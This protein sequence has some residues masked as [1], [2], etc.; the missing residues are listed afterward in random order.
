MKNSPVNLIPVLALLLLVAGCAGVQQTPVALAP[1]QTLVIKVDSYKF[2]PNY[3]QARQ[4]DL[5]IDLE[6]ISGS[7]HNI[8]IKTPQGEMLMSKDL[9]AG[10]KTSLK[11]SLPKPGIYEFY[12]DKPFHSTMGMKGRIEV[13][14]P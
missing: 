7:E 5:V 2:D 8:T 10:S 3:L 9:P 12:C 13:T 4:G 6:N 11:I 14:G 1:G